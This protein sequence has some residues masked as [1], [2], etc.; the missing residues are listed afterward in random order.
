MGLHADASVPSPARASSPEEIL[1]AALL[2]AISSGDGLRRGH[3]HHDPCNA[4]KPLVP[5]AAQVSSP[6][7]SRELTGEPQHSSGKP[8]LF[9][10]QN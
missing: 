1:A 2:A 6:L 8:P 9:L 7:D 4:L 5:P 3:L 10:V